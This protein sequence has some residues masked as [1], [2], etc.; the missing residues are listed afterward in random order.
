MAKRKHHRILR[1]HLLANTLWV[2]SSG[3]DRTD[4]ERKRFVDTAAINFDR[5]KPNVDM[6]KQT[7][8]CLAKAF[9]NHCLSNDGGFDQKRFTEELGRQHDTKH[10]RAFV[11]R[12]KYS[13]AG[14]ILDT[15]ATEDRFR[16]GRSPG[17]RADAAR[18]EAR[19]EGRGPE[20]R[21]RR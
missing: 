19:S 13:I 6:S 4:L 18:G 10:V 20:R 8:L 14:Q 1:V 11:N 21:R 16:R 9:F 5:K 3:R 12:L 2:K 7:W 17:H 15:R